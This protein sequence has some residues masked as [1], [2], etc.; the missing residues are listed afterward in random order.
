MA[1]NY[2]FTVT[3]TPDQLAEHVQPAFKRVVNAVAAEFKTTIQS[4]VFAWDSTTKRRNGSIVSDPRN[5][6]DLGGLLDGQQDPVYLNS[7]TAV[8]KWLAPYT[9][10]VFDHAQVDLVDF[11]LQRL[12][13]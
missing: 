10:L 2:Q 3:L 7:R 6:V 13:L 4:P 5:A 11:T 9:P 12:K 1:S 8:I